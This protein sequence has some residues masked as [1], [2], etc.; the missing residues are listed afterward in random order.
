MKKRT[1]YALVILMILCPAAATI[2]V[3]PA[4]AVRQLRDAR[5]QNA[6]LNGRWSCC[7][8]KIAWG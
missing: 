4:N 7:G 3:I 8:G 5:D 1:L 6:L 2:A